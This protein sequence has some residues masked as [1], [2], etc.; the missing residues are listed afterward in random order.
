MPSAPKS[1]TRVRDRERR[2][3]IVEAATHLFREKG[4]HAVGI[5]ELGAAAGIS[6]PGVYRHFGSKEDLLTA[7]FEEA[8]DD[9]WRQ[10]DGHPSVEAYVDAHVTY[11]V[12]H[13]EAIQLW[14]RE[15]RN[16]PQGAWS[17]QRRLQR[18]FIE[19][20]VDALLDERTDLD[21]YQART[22]VRAAIAAIH[23]S[24]TYGEHGGDPTLLAPMLRRAVLGTL[25][26]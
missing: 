4:F 7:V 1:A 14:Y 22:L 15:S 19:G 18:R 24:A 16:L 13:I 25:R 9:L 17:A 10:L 21:E 6:G 2:A 23:S 11:T 5:D 20:W 26:G 12:G 3:K 8:T